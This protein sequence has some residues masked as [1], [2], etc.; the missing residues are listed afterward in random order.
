MIDYA[1]FQ[2][3]TVATALSEP[4]CRLFSSPTGTGK[5]FMQ[6]D[7]LR[8]DNTILQIIPSLEIGAGFARVLGISDSR[9]SLESNRI[10]TIL[11]LLNLLN[12]GKFDVSLFKRLFFDEA[13]HTH[14]TWQ[15]VLEYFPRTPYCGFTATIYAGTP[16]ATRALHAFYGGRITT[17]LT[18][19]DAISRGVMSLPTFEVVPLHNDET[20]SVTA[21]EFKISEIDSLVKDKKEDL[22]KFIAAK[23]LNRPSMLSMSSV[24]QCKMMGDEFDHLNFPY[25]IVTAD[26]GREERKRIFDDTVACKSLMIQINVVS[27]GVDLP[28][29]R[30]YDSSPTISPRK[31]MQQT[32]RIT[33]PTD[34]QPEYYCFNH[35][36][37]RHA[38]LFEG[39][40]PA[41]VFKDYKDKWGANYKPTR[42]ALGR[43]LGEIAGLG[44]F[45]PAEIRLSDGTYALGFMLGSPD[46][47]QQYGALTTPNDTEV[48][49][50]VREFQVE[51]GQRRY[52][53]RPKWK[54]VDSLPDLTGCT[55]VPAGTLS[56]DQLNWWKKDADRVNF[57]PNGEVTNKSFQ[58]LPFCLNVGRRLKVQK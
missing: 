45:S 38:Y 15:N 28:I 39:M 9:E 1:E 41:S 52:D 27:E 36:L 50:G 25:E 23:G 40:I 42:R 35:N 12:A 56:F 5:T 11:R 4:V 16:K 13:H 53:L 31:W 48:I 37:L 19:P 21:G 7:G 24:K 6:C 33:R 29:R 10:Y 2:D 34:V 46:G 20:V 58:F 44:R 32:G 54:R 14:E 57:D 47:K 55:S 26:T 43:V 18:I 3:P 22:A 8:R 51:N 17:V 49:C 30:L